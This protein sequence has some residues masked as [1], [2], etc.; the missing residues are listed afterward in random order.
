M[1]RARTKQQLLDFGKTEFE[2]LM[3]HI[4][5][6]TEDQVTKKFIFDNRTVKDILAH[7]HA[8][9][10]LELTWYKDG[11]AGK[12]LRFPLQGIH[13]RTLLP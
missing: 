3:S 5:E 4:N 6:L 13:L 12:N 1:P 2:T 8:W 7:L 9:H 11:M 10:E